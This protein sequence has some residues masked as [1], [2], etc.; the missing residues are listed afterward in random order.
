MPQSFGR[1]VKRCICLPITCP[2]TVQWENKACKKNNPLRINMRSVRGTSLARENENVYCSRGRRW[3]RRN[4]IS[5]EQWK[6]KPISL[7]DSE[8]GRC[9]AVRGL[10]T[11]FCIKYILTLRKIKKIQFNS[12][13]LERVNSVA[14]QMLMSSG[15]WTKKLHNRLLWYLLHTHIEQIQNDIP[16]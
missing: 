16:H 15:S 8:W 5:V 2:L 10:F 1:A 4:R 9:L 7:Q 12:I 14:S 13:Q 6:S 3:K 11:D